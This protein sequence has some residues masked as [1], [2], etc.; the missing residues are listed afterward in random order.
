MTPFN[1]RLQESKNFGMSLKR[2]CGSVT[3]VE[4]TRH[5]AFDSS[6]FFPLQNFV[7]LILMH[8]NPEDFALGQVSAI[9]SLTPFPRNKQ[10]LTLERKTT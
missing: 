7:L 6:D 10:L 8:V 9:V 4:I 1:I 5:A 3:I 2:K